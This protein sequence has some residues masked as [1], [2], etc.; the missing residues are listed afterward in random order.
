MDRDEDGED[1]VDES[2]PS[3][4]LDR[5]FGQD[6]FEAGPSKATASISRSRAGSPEVTGG[7]DVKEEEGLDDVKPEIEEFD[8]KE[9]ETPMREMYSDEDEQE[10]EDERQCRICFSGREEEPALGRLISPCLCTGS[11]RVSDYCLNRVSQ[12]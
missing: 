6:P 9:E 8:I 12:S 7:P 3:S 11:V 1:W 2:L 5:T 4:P 10:P